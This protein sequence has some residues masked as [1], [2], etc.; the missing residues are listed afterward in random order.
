MHFKDLA[1]F[2]S[3]AVH[4]NIE[5]RLKVSKIFSSKMLND[6]HLIFTIGSFAKL[7]RWLY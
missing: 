6:C 1:I 7:R 3:L 2:P 5:F 4:G